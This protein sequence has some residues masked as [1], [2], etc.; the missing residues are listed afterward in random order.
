MKEVIEL[1]TI[2]KLPAQ[3]NRLQA[4][5][6]QIGSRFKSELA[7][8]VAG[9]S[10]SDLY[11][12]TI[13][14][15]ISPD[16]LSKVMRVTGEDIS[17]DH[18]V[19]IANQD[20]GGF[21]STLELAESGQ[22]DA[23]NYVKRSIAMCKQSLV[24]SEIHY[25]PCPDT[26][27]TEAHVHKED[28]ALPHATADSNPLAPSSRPVPSMPKNGD[29]ENP[30]REYRSVHV[31]GSSSALCFSVDVSRS[32]K[33]HVI[34]IEGA[35]GSNR[36]FNWGQKISLQLTFGELT[37]ITGCLLGYM[38]SYTIAAHGDNNDKFGSIERQQ[39]HY[40]ITLSQRDANK[41]AVQLTAVD[42]FPVTALF[43]EQIRRNVPQMSDALIR[44]LI[45][46]AA[47]L[48]N[49]KPKNRLAA[50]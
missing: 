9:N 16:V 33:S 32:S 44:D 5:S 29:A 1:L 46:N 10:R 45:K 20:G 30:D 48:H 15:S 41:I 35:K 47:E 38:D 6:R 39:G 37:L 14:K 36:T 49:A 19:V 17:I 26:T 25:L 7:N 43:F 27:T 31:Y 23:I 8:A 21:L 34:R 22:T 13:I 2:L 42:L 4:I 40:F 3:P 11:I 24:D 28:K 18:L 50:A 12:R